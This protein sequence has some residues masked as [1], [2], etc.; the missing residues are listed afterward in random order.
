MVTAL[1]VGGISIIK[2]KEVIKNE[3]EGKL[4]Q[5][6]QSLGNEFDNS[7][8]QIESSVSVIESTV[9]NID[10]ANIENKD[11]LKKYEANLQPIIMDTM[12]KLKGVMGA[13]V[14]FE[15]QVT[16]TNSQVWYADTERTGVFTL[17]PRYNLTDFKEDNVDMAWYYNAIRN[18]KGIWSEPFVD[19]V[20]KVNMISYTMPIYNGNKLLGVTGMDVRFDDLKKI[21]T[22]IKT[23]QTGYAFLLSK[24]YK[25]LV[26]KKL[27][28]E[29]NLKTIENGKYKFI[30]DEMD[31][32]PFGIV[33]SNFD[34]ENKIISFS[35][36]HDGKIFVIAVPE[37]EIF[38]EMLKLI[39]LIAGIMLIGIAGIA[40]L[41][42][43]IGKKISEPIVIA[44]DFINKT[45]ALD[46]G[47]YEN[48]KEA[49]LLL[50]SKDET[51]AMGSALISLRKELRNIVETIKQ[52]SHAVLDYSTRVAATA[53]E[54]VQ[55]ME[56]VSRIVEELA[57]GATE[58]AS[59]A[60][61]GAEKLNSLA[62]EINIASD[63]CT[64]VKDFS[65]QTQ[66]INEQGIQVME[67]LMEKF[68]ANIQSAEN[69]ASNIDVLANKS[70][71]IG[72]I[73]SSIQ[74]IA[75]QTNLLAL[76]AA[77]EAARAG[78]QGRGFAVVA[79]EVKNLAEQT[80]IST[81]EIADI[82]NEIQ[83]E[84][85][86]AKR[87]MDEAGNVV[88]QVNQAIKESQ[89]A[90]QEIGKAVLNTIKQIDELVGNI[91]KVD[92]DKAEVQNSIQGI[93][94]IS[95]ESAASTKEV[96]A[97]VEEQTSAMEDI[98][99]TI[100]DLKTLAGKLDQVVDKFKL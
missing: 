79:E 44:T 39:W 42:L 12:S 56:D 23:Y 78:E 30:T 72:E 67:N 28:A 15:P 99:Q 37:K 43:Y 25:F 63:S 97:S 60:Q 54:T 47:N 62:E 22:G 34:G 81:K 24:D 38:T 6:A 18:K 29:D 64:R 46:L 14:I 3:A 35:K 7:L 11:Y 26:H 33:R 36:L 27:K 94:A 51:G 31:K 74:S 8:H 59:D 92:K 5:M 9:E 88:A 90:F 45:A 70:D 21:I 61:K 58:Q 20:T 17:Q 1:V 16:G 40:C 10:L 96:S 55:S 41:A 87:N 76:N 73:I 89:K 49:Q 83:R 95:E 57:K 84:I 53:D 77:I 2:S 68:V 13:Y 86:T 48:T 85:G 69:V 4:L 91:E 66:T 100:E 52:N 75:E 50:S 98:L 82:V 65:N 19:S 80:Q 32:H 71:S 93:S